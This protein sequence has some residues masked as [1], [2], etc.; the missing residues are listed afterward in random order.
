M[1]ALYFT[2]RIREIIIESGV[3]INEKAISEEAV[4]NGMLTLRAS[5]RARIEEGLTSVEEIAAIT[6]E[7]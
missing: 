5:G 3:E 6:V 7:D 2:P 4:K 1:E